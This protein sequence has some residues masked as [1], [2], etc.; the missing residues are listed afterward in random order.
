MAS[1]T[2]RAG[3]SQSTIYDWVRAFTP[4]FIEAARSQRAPLGE[5][6]RVDETYIKVDGRWRYLFRAIDEHG[7]IVDVYLSDHRNTAAARAFFEE[8][9]HASDVTPT[10]VT[11]DKAKY[12]PSVLG[13]V[14]PLAQHRRSKYLNNPL[15][16]DHQHLKGRVRS[17]RRFKN[18]G[19]AS[20]FCRG[21]ALIRNLAGG[22][23]PLAAEIAPR[24][25]LATAWSALGAA[26]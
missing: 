23:W 26:L 4:R 1:R 17:M 11:T 3:R 5:R 13:A 18:V 6:W 9:I 14:V 24:L 21:H 12:Y 22:Y 16:R 25:R 10:E 2:R 8:A 19:A 15:E 7:Q 20:H